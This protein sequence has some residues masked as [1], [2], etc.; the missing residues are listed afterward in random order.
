[1]LL[2]VAAILVLMVTTVA[3]WARVTVFDSEKVADIVGDALAAGGQAA[4]ATT[5]APGRRC[6]RRRAALTEVL[7]DEQQRLAPVIAAGRR[8]PTT[9]GVA[10]LLANPDVQDTITG[11]VEAAHRRAME[12]LEGEDSSMA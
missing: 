2:G 10:R 4:L 9:E 8:P 3:V 11:V 6:R 5:S 12:L 1:M 7:P